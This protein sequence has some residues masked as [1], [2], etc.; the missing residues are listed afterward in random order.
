MLASSYFN[1]FV[2]RLLLRGLPSATVTA[3][4]EHREV[5]ALLRFRFAY[6][7]AFHGPVLVP[8]LE[9]LGGQSDPALSVLSLGVASVAMV[10]AD[11]PTG[12][13]ADRR[14]PGAALRLGLRLT[15]LVLVA[16]FVLSLW[17]ASVL[18]RGHHGPWLPGII[19]LLVL[20]AAIGVSLA[21]LSGADT[22][23][24]LGVL[25]RANIAGLQ[26]TGSEGVGSSVRYLGTM[27]SVAFGAVLYD[28]SS[29]LVAAPATRLALQSGLFLLTLLSQLVA[30]R[31][32]SRIAEVPPLGAGQR[33]PGF[34]DVARGLAAL[35]R[36]PGFALQ[37]WL[38]CLLAA[39]ALFAVYLFQS[40]LNR[41]TSE[42]VG[43][44][45]LWAPLYVVTA[46][47]GYWA[48][49]RGSRDAHRR[50]DRDALSLTE[51]GAMAPSYGVAV[52]LMATGLGLLLLYPV[53]AALLQLGPP[54]PFSLWLG[55]LGFVIAAAGN[56]LL[57][58]Y[59]RGFVEPYSAAT[60]VTFTQSHALSVP[61]SI[62][63]GFNSLKR[64]M[65]FVLSLLFYVVRSHGAATLPLAPDRE[66]ARML[67]YV[68]AGLLALALPAVAVVFVGRGGGASVEGGGA[69]AART[70]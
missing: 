25:R 32:L 16:F 10:L 21:L 33:R 54:T 47:L 62:I 5:R 4:L 50:H 64:G 30:L 38:L 18:A 67:L 8:L 17:R 63:S 68:V 42:L 13:Y 31:E 22:V 35:T 39:V 51:A 69:G 52:R 43:S 70:S 55:R 27:I 29:W 49:S 7:F 45:P 15:C 12:L 48:C 24:F 57:F 44:S 46:V 66:L 19:G 36:F 34:R 1:W 6:L 40:P 37:M 58:N 26:S 61:A 20:E 60:L 2:R 59:V 11:V 56:C 28:L 23:L 65:H 9:A 41:L 14:G 53:I 3:C